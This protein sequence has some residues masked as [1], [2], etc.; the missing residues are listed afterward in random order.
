MD[1]ID[2]VVGTIQCS[3]V[4][5]YSTFHCRRQ[6]YVE[7]SNFFPLSHLLAQTYNSLYSPR[8]TRHSIATIKTRD[9]SPHHKANIRASL[10]RRLCLL[11]GIQRLR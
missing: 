9:K 8:R 7:G 2:W 1:W 4:D 10:P 5:D 6:G 3:V 11:L